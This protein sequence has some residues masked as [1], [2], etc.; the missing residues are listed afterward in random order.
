MEKHPTLLS[1]AFQRSDERLW[2]RTMGLYSRS[3]EPPVVRFSTTL[4]RS[5]RTEPTLI[6]VVGTV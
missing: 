4:S 6:L 1:I 2:E 5:R 3:Y